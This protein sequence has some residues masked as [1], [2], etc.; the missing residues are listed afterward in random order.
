MYGINKPS[1]SYAIAVRAFISRCDS[2]HRANSSSWTARKYFVT[3]SAPNESN[4]SNIS[5]KVSGLLERAE[6]DLAV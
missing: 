4:R 6:T 3:C 2:W 1:V 5:W